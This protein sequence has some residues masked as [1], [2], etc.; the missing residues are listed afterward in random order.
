MKCLAFLVLLLKFL[1][2]NLLT[3]LQLRDICTSG[4]IKTK[5]SKIHAIVLAHAF[6]LILLS[7][8]VVGAVNDEL[9]GGTLGLDDDV[10][11]EDG[12]GL[13]VIITV[14][15]IIS[16]SLIIMIIDCSYS[17]SLSI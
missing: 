15:I 8:V 7:A 9:L 13:V 14:R 10:V 5:D 11:D 4:C 1:R 17:Y 12:V 2:P 6:L 3:L 16:Y